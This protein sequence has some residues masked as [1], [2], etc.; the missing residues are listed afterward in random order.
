M[1]YRFTNKDIATLLRDMNAAYELLGENRFKIIAYEK[2]KEVIENLANEVS[3]YFESGTLDKIPGIGKTLAGHLTELFTKGSV[4]HFT[5][6]FS[7]LPEAIFPLLS[8]PG[9]GPKKA[10]LLVTSLHF[11]DKKTVIDDLERACLEHKIASLDRFGDKSEE[12]ILQN[13]ST[14]KKG[15]VKENRI[16]INQADKIAQDMIDYLKSQCKIDTIEVLGSV[17]R[18]V[19]TIGD[20]DIAVVS[21][22]S[23]SVI[24]AFCAFPFSTLIER[25][26]T[27]ASIRLSS[28]TQ[29]DLR[30]CN[31][32]EWGSMIQY[33]TGSKYHNITLR[34]H[35]L[36]KGLSLSEYGLK[37]EYERTK[38]LKEIGKK[39]QK[40]SILHF[41]TE[42]DLYIEL[43]LQWIPPELREDKGEIEAALHNKLPTLIEHKDIKGDLHMHSSYDLSSS[44]DL[45]ADTIKDLLVQATK[46]QYEY[47]GI[48]D[49][50]PKFGDLSEKDIYS[51]MKAR[52]SFYEQQYSSYTKSVHKDQQK[53]PKLF[54]MLE[55]DIRPDGSLAL[56]ESCFEFIDAAIISVHSSFQMDKESMTNRILK[57]M[58]IQPKVRILG[59]PTG[60]LIGKRDGIDADWDQ[61][62]ESAKDHDIA[63]EINANTMRLDLPEHMVKIAIEKNAKICIN[64]DAH[65]KGG[66]LD[67]PYGVDTARRGWATSNDIINT[68]GYNDFR[69]WL[70]KV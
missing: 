37:K 42:K 34:E 29:I 31:K 3:D 65:W 59:H 12:S 64:S 61:I 35:A 27:G 38:V 36:T 22:D 30:I 40:P 51:I 63:L 17:R 52:K 32:D 58:S 68:K 25:G 55:I 33:F 15:H 48:S 24:T 28:G 5:S 8:I 7:R 57:A 23:E 18:R 67:I 11:S 6:T 39:N 14:F 69:K 13:I 2:A 56:P 26:K 41:S 10:F 9:I 44:H 50:N 62:I 70:I 21:P 66:L 20:I 60:R 49:H 1:I 16:H 4:S 54:I 43:G 53:Y 46:L 47:I 45:G 19:S